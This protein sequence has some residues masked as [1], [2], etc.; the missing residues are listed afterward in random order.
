MNVQIPYSRCKAGL[1]LLV[2]S[3]GIKFLGES[4]WKCKKH[5]T[6]YRCPW[7]KLHADTLQIRSICVMGNNVS[8]TS[9]LCDLLEQLPQ[10]KHLKVLPVM[11][12]K[13]HSPPTKR[14]SGTA[15]PHHSTTHECA[16]ELPR[17]A[18]A[19]GTVSESAGLAITYE[20]WWKRRGTASKDWASG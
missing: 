17:R 8:D 3:T 1:D 5:G 20:V 4:E 10:M 2:D 13:I 19:W 14:S 16:G 6:E 12:L 11:V 18:G 7:R 15:L 9:V